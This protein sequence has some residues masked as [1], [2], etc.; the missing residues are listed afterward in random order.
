MRGGNECAKKAV[1]AFARK[2]IHYKNKTGARGIQQPRGLEE[3]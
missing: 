2:L 3:E 1:A